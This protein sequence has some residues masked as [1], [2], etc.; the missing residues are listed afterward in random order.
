MLS[1][2][3]WS[4][5]RLSYYDK[6]MLDIVQEKVLECLQFLTC[7]ELCLIA[8]GFAKFKEGSY[9]F[10]VDILNRILIMKNEMTFLDIANVCWSVSRRDIN[11]P[12]F[13]KEIE[14]TINNVILQ[15]QNP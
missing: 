10:W 12:T 1:Y 11:I 9:D 7:R 4:L 5:S 13:W 8:W 15:I 14:D 3:V 2:V 6:E